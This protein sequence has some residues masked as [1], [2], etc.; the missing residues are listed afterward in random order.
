MHEVAPRRRLRPVGGMHPGR[1]A[2]RVDLDAAVVGQRRQAVARAAA[3]AL[4]RA[5]PRKLASVSAGSGSPSAPAETSST[6]RSPISAR[7]S[8]SLPRLWVATTSRGSTSR[9]RHATAARCAAT[10][11]ATPV[12]GEV[13]QRV[14]LRPAEGRAL[15]AALHLDEPAAVGHH[16]IGV[17]PGGAVLGIVEVEHRLAAVDAAADRGD[18]RGQR[19]ALDHPA[20]HQLADRQSQRDPAAGDRRAAGA[21]VGLQHVAVDG[22]L[23]LAERHPVDPGPQAAPDQPLDL[24]RPPRL[25]AGRSPRAGSASSSRAAACRTRR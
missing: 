14:E 13:E 2:E 17:R 6:G 1:A 19:V 20:C 25:L 23:P 18:M 10:S 3:C 11:A 16:E 9:R 24:L 22:D 4:I 8:S 12:L 15:G 5:L 21:A 7:I